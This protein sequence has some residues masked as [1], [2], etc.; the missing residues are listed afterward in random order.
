LREQVVAH[1]FQA[2]VIA[3]V[4]DEGERHTIGVILERRGSV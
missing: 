1:H 4:G 3:V 2:H